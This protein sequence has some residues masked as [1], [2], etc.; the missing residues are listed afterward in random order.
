MVG[1]VRGSEIV[2]GLITMVM[3]L[4]WLGFHGALPWIP[5]LSPLP[6]IPLLGPLPLLILSELSNCVEGNVYICS[7]CPFSQSFLLTDFQVLPVQLTAAPYLSW[8]HM[9]P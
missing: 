2:I 8:F 4:E 1:I 6:E 3:L 5:L 9:L 7:S